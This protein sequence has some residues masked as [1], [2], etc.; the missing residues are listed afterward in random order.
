ME[1][2][3]CQELANALKY[4]DIEIPS[5]IRNNLGKPLRPYQEEGIKHYLLQRKNPKTNHLMFNMA[6]GSGKTL[7]MAALMLE[8]YKQGYRDFVFFVNS[9]T[10]LEKTKA[11]FADNTSSKYLFQGEIILDSERIEINVINNFNDSLQNCINIHF[12]TIQSLCSLLKDEKENTLTLEDLRDKKLVLLADEAH[13][14][15]SDTKRTKPSREENNLKEGWET[16]VRKVFESHKENLLLEFTATIPKDPNV[17]K[18]YQDKIAYQYNLK[19]FCQNGFSKRIFMMKYENKGINDRFLGGILLSLYRE[20][21][22]LKYEIRLKP[23]VFFKSKYKSESLENKKSFIEFMQNLD[24]F[25]IKSFYKERKLSDLFLESLHFFERYFEC[26]ED[27]CFQKIAEFLKNNF[28]THFIIDANCEK[29][30]EQNQIRLNSLED[31]DNEIRVIFAI[32]K[33]DEG[34][35][36]L[37]LFDIVRLENKTTNQRETTKE[38]QLIGRG[39]R[40]YPFQSKKIELDPELTYKR[41]FDNDLDNELSMLERLSYHTI[42]ESDFITNLNKSMVEQGI[43]FEDLKEYFELIPNEKLKK[44]TDKKKVYYAKNK[45]IERLELLRF[46]EPK[47]VKSSLDSM[48]IPLISRNIQEDEETFETKDLSPTNKSEI[49]HS[50]SKIPHDCFLKAMNILGLNFD[51]LASKFKSKSKNEFIQKNLGSIEGYFSRKQS[52]TRENCLEIAKYIL[53]NL[54]ELTQT[55]VREY[56]ITEFVAHRL[57]ISNFDYRK[58]AIHK[59]S[60]KTT[61]DYDWLYYSKCNLNGLEEKFLSFIE[62]HREKIDAAFVEWFVIRNERF[63]EFKIYGYN[64]N[65]EVRGFEPDFI[66]FGRKEGE[67]NFL[68]TECFMEAKGG[69]LEDKDVWKQEFLNTLDGKRLPAENKTL[70]LRSLPFFTGENDT[71]FQKAFKKFLRNS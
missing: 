8:C 68:G 33:L 31:E 4:N 66:F 19:D 69:H 13:H 24:A 36:V 51:Q 16:I 14:L 54:G 67:E 40:Y 12:T 63:E 9:R 47:E 56:E 60:K 38:A 17:T 37:N 34:W 55:E 48:E 28:K 7:M 3:L 35:D 64:K 71:E 5:Y 27:S 2:L 43:S 22:A 21:V 6:T 49:A 46:M 41:K 57:Y 53:K 65:K 10:I 44:I 20:L 30:W 58:I 18:K 32:N 45:K 39:A 52:F 70:K 25:Y 1:Q 11:N 15:N 29:E 26:E 23:V 62:A 59:E 61:H 42:N 50:F